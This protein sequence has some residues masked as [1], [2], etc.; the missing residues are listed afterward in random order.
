[1]NELIPY[2]DVTAIDLRD[3]FDDG[4]RVGGFG[5]TE[6]SSGHFENEEFGRYVLARYNSVDSCIVVHHSG[7]VLVF[8]LDTTERTIHLYDEM[9]S[10]L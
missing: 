9:R 4:R 2:E 10:R 5:G 7:E 3:S 1:M 6:V 8:N